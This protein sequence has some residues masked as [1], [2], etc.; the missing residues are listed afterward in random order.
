M[1]IYIYD[2]LAPNNKSYNRIKRMF[3]YYLTQI[4]TPEVKFI[5]KSTL[6]VPKNLESLFDGFFM[7]W[8]NKLVVYKI[9]SEEFVKF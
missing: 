3:Y 6:F 8:K 5:T 7:K 2:I 9:F 4:Q 1:P